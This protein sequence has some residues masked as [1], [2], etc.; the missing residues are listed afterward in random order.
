MPM[1]IR[2]LRTETDYKWGLA[3]IAPYF[4]FTI[5]PKLRL[6]PPRACPFNLRPASTT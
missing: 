1:H 6:D 3:D 5:H 4:E 2:P